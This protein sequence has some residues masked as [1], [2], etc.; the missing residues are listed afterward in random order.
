VAVLWVWQKITD[1]SEVLIASVIRV[2]YIVFFYFEGGDYVSEL[3]SLTDIFFIP[4]MM[5]VWRA[6]V[7]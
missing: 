6:M 7:G 3:L 4:Q 1:V 5:I 2:R